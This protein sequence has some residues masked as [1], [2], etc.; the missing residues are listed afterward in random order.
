MNL[1]KKLQID[2]YVLIGSLVISAISGCKTAEE[3]TEDETRQAA[4]LEE[5]FN[6][7]S[8]IRGV[9]RQVQ[10]Y[11]SQT[12]PQNVCFT[13]QDGTRLETT[14]ARIRRS[15]LTANTEDTF[16]EDQ[17]RRMH[18]HMRASIGQEVSVR[19]DLTNHRAYVINSGGTTF[20]SREE[21]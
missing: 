18:T 3:R 6:N 20:D 11:P 4:A 13:V 9:L 19:Y 16:T 14:C 7:L 5:R 1:R 8:E 21:N 12:T 10:E 15:S 2:K 17:L